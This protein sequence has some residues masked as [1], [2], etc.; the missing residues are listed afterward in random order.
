MRADIC[1]PDSQRVG[2]GLT[3]KQGAFE[4]GV[5]AGNHREGVQAQDITCFQRA[6]SHRVVRTIGI[7]TGLEP[8]PGITNFATRIG[9]RNFEFHRVT[10]DHRDIDFAGAYLDRVANCLAADIGG[11]GSTLDQFDFLGRLDQA[12]THNLT[13]QIAGFDTA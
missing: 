13:I 4:R 3:D 1:L 10:T 12:Q 8:D 2:I 5:I 9:T 7:E 6:R 11:T